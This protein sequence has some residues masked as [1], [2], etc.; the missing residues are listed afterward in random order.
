MRVC[1]VTPFAWSVPHEVNDHVAGVAK[2]LRVLGHSVTV[3]A[4]SSRT[5][6]LLAGR[7]ALARRGRRRG[8]RDRP[9]RAGLAAEQHGRPG[10]RARKPDDRALA[11]RVR[12][13][14]RVRA[15][16]AEPLLPRAPLRA[17]DLGRELLLAR[18]ARLPAR[19]GPARA[20]ARPGR[21]ADRGLARDRRGRGRALP[22]RLP[23]RLAGRRHRPPPARAG[24][25]S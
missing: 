11:R 2:E 23:R 14:P 17:H 3:L 5:A 22:R 19:Q 18:A 12:R 7:R 21:R 20:A 8:D 1:L 16:A 10:R 9:G 4:P 6:D 25:G 15:R 24:S 13:R